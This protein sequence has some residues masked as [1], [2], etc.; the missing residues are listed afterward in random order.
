[1]TPAQVTGGWLRV[2]LGIATGA[3]GEPT[4]T[5]LFTNLDQPGTYDGTITFTSTVS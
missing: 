5:E 3:A 4:G 1:V 2:Y